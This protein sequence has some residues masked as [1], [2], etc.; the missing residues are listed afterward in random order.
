M[1]RAYTY[2]LSTTVKQSQPPRN[3]K[4]E[5]AG[6]RVIAVNPAYTSQPCSTCDHVAKENRHEQRFS[7][8]ACGFTEHAN[9]NAPHATS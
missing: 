2:R 7:C 9:V 8:V 5:G 4:A 6:R 1:H 3:Y